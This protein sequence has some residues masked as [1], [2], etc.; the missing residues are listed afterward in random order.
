MVF[1]PK[2][3]R[4]PSSPD[5]PAGDDLA[6]ALELRRCDAED[7]DALVELLSPQERA[8]AERFRQADDRRRFILGRGLL[9]TMLG[10]QL[11][12]PPAS[13]VF[14]ANPHG[15]PTLADARGIA[16]NVS[17]SGDYVL[18]AV[19]RAAAIGVD[20]ERVRPDVDV[21]GV[22]RQVFTPAERALIAAAP[23]A[24]KTA[25]FFRQWTLKE[26]VAKAV[27][28]GLSLDL[29]R[30]E[31]TFRNETPELAPHGA[32]ELG[33]ASDWRLWEAPVDGGHC[34]ALAVRPRDASG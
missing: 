34:A 29:K 3:G 1:F 20:V 7:I 28:L 26:A 32:P 15:K 25:L 23:D 24:R 11:D 16:F 12:L 6:I 30:F 33:A 18:V 4:P 10:R 5:A 21:A 8:R 14:G 22:G 17:H 2:P 19:G 9:R 13:L 27:G 31:I